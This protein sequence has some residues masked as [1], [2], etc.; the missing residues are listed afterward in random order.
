MMKSQATRT[1]QGALCGGLKSRRVS[2][3]LHMR[4]IKTGLTC[5]S[6]D[7]GQ[8]DAREMIEASLSAQK[9]KD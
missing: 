2:A 1:A 9:L 4:R 6:K 8:A 7:G 3:K 5:I